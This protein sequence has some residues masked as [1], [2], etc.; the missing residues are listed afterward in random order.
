MKYHYGKG[1]I[2]LKQIHFK[3]A[4][5]FRNHPLIH[6]AFNNNNK[7]KIEKKTI[8]YGFGKSILQCLHAESFDRVSRRFKEKR[9][10]LFI[11]ML[12]SL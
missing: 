2:S 5:C 8:L 6:A 4:F 1:L 11:R 3:R 10:F 7:M 12:L 9:N